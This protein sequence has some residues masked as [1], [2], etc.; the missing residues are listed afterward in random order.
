MEASSCLLGRGECE[1]R[2]L[3]AVLFAQG[4]NSKLAVADL[5]W[6]LKNENEQIRSSEMAKK[7][8]DLLEKVRS[9]TKEEIQKIVEA[10]GTS[11]GAGGWY[12]GTHWNTCPNGHLF[13]I[14]DCGGAMVESKCPD[15]GSVVGGRSHTLAAGNKNVRSMDAVV[16]TAL[17]ANAPVVP[18]ARV[19]G[20]PAR[21]EELAA[22]AAPVRAA[23]DAATI[24]A[25]QNAEYYEALEQDRLAALQN[26]VVA[27]PLPW[28]NAPPPEVDM[29]PD[30]IN[31]RVRVRDINM[32]RRFLRGAGAAD[33]IAW[34]RW[35]M[36]EMNEELPGRWLLVA[37]RPRREI[38]LNA[39][40]SLEEL[41]IINNSTLL[42]ENED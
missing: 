17:A 21:R 7:A 14:G 4:S 39:E 18:V 30:V 38:R 20:V 33:V 41:G 10:M 22:P 24:I 26:R 12:N 15:C 40:E 32:Q 6:I 3:R 42:L 36:R 1:A 9:L 19:D 34:V 28:P 35:R 16:N 5:E 29:G 8:Q 23:N 13:V 31:L 27:E 11:A 37:D 2:L 25:R